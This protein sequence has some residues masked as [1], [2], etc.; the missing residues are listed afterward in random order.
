MAF[1][2][3]LSQVNLP[4]WPLVIHPHLRA[5]EEKQNR[6]CR[7]IVTSKFTFLA[8]SYSSYL[9]IIH[10]SGGKYPPLSPTLR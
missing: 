8:L 5:A 2:G 7:Y 9:T 1:V 4:F 10:R 6:F 3:T